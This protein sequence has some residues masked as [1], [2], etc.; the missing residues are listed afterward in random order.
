[1]QYALAFLSEKADLLLKV[2][3]KLERER[4]NNTHVAKPQAS[5]T[6]SYVATKRVC[7]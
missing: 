1:M 4:Q 7:K 5:N 6:K 3:S 2:K